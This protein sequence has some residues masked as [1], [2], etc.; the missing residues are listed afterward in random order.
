MFPHGTVFCLSIWGTPASSPSPPRPPLRPAFFLE[1]SSLFTNCLPANGSPG[2][3]Q[4]LYP[5]ALD[6]SSLLRR[7]EPLAAWE[8]PMRVDEYKDFPLVV[9]FFQLS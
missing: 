6:T 2:L 5:V 1:N 9:F 8:L 7:Q 3:P 4:R